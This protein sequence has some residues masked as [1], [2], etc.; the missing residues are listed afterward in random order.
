MLQ[1]PGTCWGGTSIR[2]RIMRKLIALTAAA[3]LASGAAL[4]CDDNVGKCEI[5]DWRWYSN[6]GNILSIE[7]VTTCDAGE[8]VIRLYEGEGGR[9][10]GS[11]DSFTNAHTFTAIAIEI[12]KPSALTFKYGIE[13]GD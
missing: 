5:E 1:R 3:M 4:A 12:A 11:I 9:F 13:S 10:L 7:G 8:I 6:P 2:V